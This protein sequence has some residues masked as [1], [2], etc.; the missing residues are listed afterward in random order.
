MDTGRCAEADLK[1]FWRVTSELRLGVMPLD[2]AIDE[3][4]LLQRFTERDAIRRRCAAV[5]AQFEADAADA[6]A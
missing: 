5:L 4:V 2:E 6:L 3:L 1:H